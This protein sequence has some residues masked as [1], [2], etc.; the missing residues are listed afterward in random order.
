MNVIRCGLGILLCAAVGTGCRRSAPPP[1]A[2]APAQKPDSL[3]ESYDVK[4]MDKASAAAVAT[5]EDFM[6]RLK[7]PQ[8]GDS[9][10]S[11]KVRIRDANRFEDFWVKEPKL[12]QEPYSGIIGN[13]PGVVRNVKFRQQYSFLRSQIVDWMYKSNGK[14]QG[15]YTLHVILKSLPSDEA[16]EL[17]RKAGW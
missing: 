15:N 13:E 9:D 17:R 10:F 6:A 4:A 16:D 8:P 3:V 1:D 14:V 5:L 7:E 2:G 12:D 11:V